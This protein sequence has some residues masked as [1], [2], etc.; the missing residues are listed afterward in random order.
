MDATLTLLL[1]AKTFAN[2]T[3]RSLR[4][5]GHAAVQNYKFFPAIEE[6]ATCTVP[7]IEQAM[8][9]FDENWPADLAWPDGVRRGL[10]ILR[11]DAA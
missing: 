3:G 7:K 10:P 5:I 9:W 8:A 4:S 2:A 1:V 6:G 11:S